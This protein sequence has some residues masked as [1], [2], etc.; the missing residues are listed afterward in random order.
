MTNLVDDPRC[1][2]VMPDGQICEG[3]DAHRTE[4]PKNELREE[5]DKQDG[6]V[7]C[8][9]CDGK[10]YACYSCCTQE[11]ITDD[12]LMCPVCHE[13]LGEEECDDCDGTGKVPEEKTDFVDHAPS[14]QLAAESMEDR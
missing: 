7:E 3:V 12:I 1:K 13:H 10:G 14:M 6:L 5:F 11:L 9:T 8:L 2:G 4:C